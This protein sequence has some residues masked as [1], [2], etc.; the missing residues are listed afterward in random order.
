M[1]VTKTIWDGWTITESTIGYMGVGAGAVGCSF[2]YA[3][4]IT[5]GADEIVIIDVDKS[6]AEGEVMDLNHGSFFTPP[7]IISAGD[8]KDCED[9]TIVVI[10]AGAKQKPGQSRLELVG[11]NVGICTE[12]MGWVMKHAPEA[13]ILMVA[14]PV[15]ILT[16]SALKC[17]GLP[18]N[19]VIGSGTVLDSARFRFLLSSS[20]LDD[21]EQTSFSLE[22]ISLLK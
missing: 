16:Y 17:S 13:V 19:Q 12:I 18:R 22:A 9:A 4:Q 14:N 21:N 2:V 7:V 15:D 6:R 20:I 3:L 10:T 11:K 5:G 8:P 1:E